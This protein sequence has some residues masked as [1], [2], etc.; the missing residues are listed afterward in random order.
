MNPLRKLLS[1]GTAAALL[2]LAAMPPA[3]S[4]AKP[5]KPKPAATKPNQAVAREIAALERTANALSGEVAALTARTAT[6][7]GAP[8]P[9]TEVSTTGTPTPAPPVPASGDFSGSFPDPKL[10]PH[11]VGVDQIAEGAI[12]GGQVIDNSILGFSIASKT[13][14]GGDIGALNGSD[15]SSAVSPR[16]LE[17]VTYLE[18]QKD[19]FELGRPE[20]QTLS[21]STTCPN[22]I[23]SG[24]W[25]A[26]GSS[27]GIEIM[28]SVPAFFENGRSP[29]RDW[30]VAARE[31]LPE[32]SKRSTFAA[33]GLCLR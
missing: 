23:V 26:G 21:L 24:G 12:D 3:A 25:R 7:E 1:I 2:A 13:L 32:Q 31:Q 17:D 11:A 16:T 4:L 15:F 22:R 8:R 5:K 10:K 20:G 9:R 18:G 30:I 29:E 33:H 27:V 14:L 6:L 28:A 19:V